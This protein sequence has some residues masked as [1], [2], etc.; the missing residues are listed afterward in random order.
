MAGHQRISYL[1]KEPKRRELY[2]RRFA[3]QPHQPVQGDAGFPGE[4]GQASDWIR[5]S[6]ADEG[7]SAPRATTASPSTSAELLDAAADPASGLRPREQTDPEAGPAAA[8]LDHRPRRHQRPMLLRTVAA[9]RHIPVSV[10][11]TVPFGADQAFHLGIH[12]LP[13]ATGAAWMTRFEEFTAHS[14]EPAQ[15]SPRSSPH[16]TSCPA[17]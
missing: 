8:G 11:W 7:R 13:S 16:S 6:C 14:G 5:T 9:A 2:H 1:W 12:N 17:S 3:A 15:L 10:E 4:P